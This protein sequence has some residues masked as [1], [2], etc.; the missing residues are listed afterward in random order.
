LTQYQT[1]RLK[2]ARATLAWL[3]EHET[4]IRAIMAAQRQAAAAG[5]QTTN[6]H[7]AA[8]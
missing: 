3:A 1:G 8:P 6:K 5:I 7:D 2:A 4:E